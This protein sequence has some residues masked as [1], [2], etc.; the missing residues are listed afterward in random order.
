MVGGTATIDAKKIGVDGDFDVVVE[1]KDKAGHSATVNVGT[2]TV[3]GTPPET[4]VALDDTSVATQPG[5]QTTTTV[6][7]VLR[8]IT[9]NIE[10]AEFYVGPGDARADISQRCSP[11]TAMYAADGSFI[12]DGN[13]Y[14]LNPVD[15]AFDSGFEEAANTV[16]GDFRNK[17]IFV[18]AKDSAGN[19]EQTKAI[20]M[21][22]NGKIID[23]GTREIKAA[24][25]EPTPTAL[26]IAGQNLTSLFIVVAIGFAGVVTILG[27]KFLKFSFFKLFK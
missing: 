25:V 16:N 22:Q 1:A 12:D 17:C 24:P 6:R 11:T 10:S 14:D 23:L 15:G 7:A 21:L 19:W 5:G 18:H 8:D 26:P 9:S 13:R 4:I 20:Y 27:K 3:D 2:I